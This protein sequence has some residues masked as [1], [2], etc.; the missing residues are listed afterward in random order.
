MFS[1]LLANVSLPIKPFFYCAPVSYLDLDCTVPI[2]ISGEQCGFL[3]VLQL[4]F[5]NF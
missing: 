5:L 4:E 1:Y 3:F 2:F